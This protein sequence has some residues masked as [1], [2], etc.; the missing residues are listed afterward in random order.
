M[1]IQVLGVKHACQGLPGE[2]EVEGGDSS[3]LCYF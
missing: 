1:K 2:S 3:Q